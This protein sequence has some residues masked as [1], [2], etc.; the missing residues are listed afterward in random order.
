MSPYLSGQQCWCLRRLQR[1]RT[2]GRPGG[3]PGTHEARPRTGA[4]PPR[5]RSASPA[6]SS[7]TPASA[8]SSATCNCQAL[9]QITH[10]LIAVKKWLSYQHLPAS[11]LGGQV[12]CAFYWANSPEKT[13][14]V[15]MQQEQCGVQVVLSVD[16]ANHLLFFPLQR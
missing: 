2:L 10:T 11:Q 7:C 5:H 14:Q 13:H 6:P 16:G 8:D 4:G 15:P 12:V 1:E 9:V 3:G